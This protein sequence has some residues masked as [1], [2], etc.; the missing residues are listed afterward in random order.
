MSLSQMAGS[1][2]IATFIATV[3]TVATRLQPSKTHD[4]QPLK[5]DHSG[6]RLPSYYFDLLQ[7]ANSH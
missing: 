4:L 5:A 7:I 2:A 1:E 3:Y 6:N